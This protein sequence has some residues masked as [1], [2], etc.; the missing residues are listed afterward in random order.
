MN[1]STKVRLAV[2][3]IA[4]GTVAVAA[5][6]ASADTGSASVTGQG[7][8]SPGLTENGDPSNEFTIGLSGYVVVTNGAIGTLSC[9]GSGNDEIGSWSQGAG[10]ISTFCDGGGN[11]S[12]NFVR[13]GT[14]VTF[15]GT[16]SGF[17][18]GAI[19]GPCDFAPTNIDPN[20]QRVTAF[21]L[22]CTLTIS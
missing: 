21:A 8:I 6:P 5:L 20:G 9:R 22:S 4:I 17:F 2:A 18:N 3:S 13:T 16:V 1:G 11:L 10:G 7:T 19:T 15:S 14:L 12:G